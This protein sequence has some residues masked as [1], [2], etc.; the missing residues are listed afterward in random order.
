MV[1]KFE[2][3]NTSNTNGSASNV[4]NKRLVVVEDNEQTESENKSSCC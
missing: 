4:G 1:K 2:Q 3:S